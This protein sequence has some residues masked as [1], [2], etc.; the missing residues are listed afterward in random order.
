[1]TE[2]RDGDDAE[3]EDL[4][5]DAEDGDLPVDAED[6][7]LPGDAEDGRPPYSRPEITSTCIY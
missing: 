2:G 5:V 1:M 7:D 6:G 4:P 3:D